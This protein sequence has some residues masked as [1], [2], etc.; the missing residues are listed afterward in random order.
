M[1]RVR[2]TGGL[3]LVMLAQATVTFPLVRGACLIERV[4]VEPARPS[5]FQVL[6]IQDCGTR[7][8]WERYTIVDGHRVRGARACSVRDGLYQAAPEE[9]S[10]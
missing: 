6:E 9:E 4:I 8:C 2:V 10:R 1:T 3:A 5:T 7:L